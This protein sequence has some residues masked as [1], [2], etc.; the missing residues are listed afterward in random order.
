MK[1]RIYITLAIL[2]VLWMNVPVQAE[3]EVIRLT[4]NDS[5]D[6]FPAVNG[7]Y[8]VWQGYQDGDWEVFLYDIAA[9]QTVQVSAN[10]YD[11]ISA[12]TD[13]NYVV[14]LGMNAAGGN[15]FIYEI[16][17]GQN[18]QVTDNGKIKA[19]PQIADGRIVWAA[20]E[21]AESVLPG[22][23]ELYEIDTGTT[24]TISAEVD[25]DGILDDN[26][27]LIGDN[28]VVWVQ[29]GSNH[30]TTTLFIH[31]L[32]TGATYPAPDDF[33]KGFGPTRSG[34]LSITTKF[35]GQDRE[36]FLNHLRLRKNEQITDNS[37]EERQPAIHGNHLVWVGSQGA[38]QE[39]YL[40]ITRS[41]IVVSPGDGMISHENKY[42]IFKWDG[43]G[44]D[45]FKVQ[46][47]ST[48]DFID[49]W[50]TVTFPWP[51]DVWLYET[52]F[53]PEKWQ[54]GQLN[55]LR[56][57]Q[58]PLYWR[59]LARDKYGNEKISQ[60]QSFVMGPIKRSKTGVVTDHGGC[61]HNP[62]RQ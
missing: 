46:F 7:N 38:E 60:V 25:P 29:T 48:R 42:P 36:V 35:D 27:P 10:G 28:K 3:T 14:W 22:E 4:D 18:T 2:A 31:N 5:M 37:I 39:I 34:N 12:R 41:L 24:T 13:G 26:T 6:I 9:A 40:G 16:S 62:C 57:K 54:A 20:Q 61:S 45:R 15:I 32:T 53:T 55:R 49:N 23:I 1:N 30:I 21:V 50:T 43:I 8:L 56:E 11:D 59:V 44:Y 52:S 51:D 17:T 33:T 58:Q 47:S 19:W